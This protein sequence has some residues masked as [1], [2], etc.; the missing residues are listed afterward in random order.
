MRIW[1]KDAPKGCYRK[2]RL[3]STLHCS[4][5]ERKSCTAGQ[6]WLPWVLAHRWTCQLTSVAIR[7]DVWKMILKVLT[8]LCDK[9]WWSITYVELHWTFISRRRLTGGTLLQ[10]CQELDSSWVLSVSGTMKLWK[11]GSVLQC[12]KGSEESAE[13]KLDRRWEESGLVKR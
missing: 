8:W 3:V 6:W 7:P 11:Q 9:T 5:W 10:I 1:V 2:G 13:L 12:L 4:K